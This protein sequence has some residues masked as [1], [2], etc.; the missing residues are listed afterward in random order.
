ILSSYMPEQL[1]AEELKKIIEDVIKEL[2]ATSKS[3]MGKV[4]KSVMERVK[5]RADGKKISQIVSS[6]L[7]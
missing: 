3:E 7:R 4:M 6:M 2:E 5:G 1:S